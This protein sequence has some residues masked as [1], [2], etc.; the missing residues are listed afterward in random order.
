MTI[1]TRSLVAA[2]V[3]ETCSLAVL[4]VNLATVHNPVVSGTVGL[5][6]GMAHLGTIAVAT[7]LSAPTRVKALSLVPGI[8]GFL[9]LR[10]TRARTS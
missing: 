4:L 6:H 5:L 10:R 7:L 2:S 8:G 3:T 1:S 9:T